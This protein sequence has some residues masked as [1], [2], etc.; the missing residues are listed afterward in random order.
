MAFL[1][2]A[3]LSLPFPAPSSVDVPCMLGASV[4][5]RGP[6]SP[7]YCQ[8]NCTC[9]C[10][11]ADSV[12]LP[13]AWLGPTHGTPFWDVNIQKYK[14]LQSKVFDFMYS[15]LR[16]QIP[17][18][19]KALLVWPVA[20]PYTTVLGSVL[21]WT[22]ARR[23]CHL[24]GCDLLGQEPP[25]SAQGCRNPHHWYLKVLPF[26]IP[27]APLSLGSQQLQAQSIQAGH[28]MGHHSSGESL[29]EGKML[30]AWRRVG[31]F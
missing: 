29:Q 26:R 30:A 4:G 19:A 18:P 25:P 13:P 23:C 28:R 10:L 6:L 1:A 5:F 3:A 9:Q 20:V 2:V 22:H 27:G 14:H 11:G 16:P 31:Q 21:T 8:V 12:E 17:T 15:H 24:S 7:V